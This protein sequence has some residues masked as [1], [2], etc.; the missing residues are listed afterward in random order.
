[1]GLPPVAKCTQHTVHL[2]TSEAFFHTY[3]QWNSM[4]CSKLSHRVKG[5]K[6]IIEKK[7]NYVSGTC[8]PCAI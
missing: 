5:T 6:C 8:P 1:M 2:S 7:H 3:Q 4:G